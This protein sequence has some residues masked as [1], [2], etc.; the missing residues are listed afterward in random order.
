LIYGSGIDVNKYSSN[1]FER[2]NIRRD[3]GIQEEQ[4]LFICVTRLIW[5]KG[6]KELVDAFTLVHADNK[7]FILYIVGWPDYDNPRHVTDQFINS[8]TKQSGINFL[9]KRTDIPELLA[10]SDLFIFPSYY[11]EGIPRNLLEALAMGLP[12]ITTDMPGCRMAV[13]NGV[14]GLLIQPRSVEEI[15]TAFRKIFGL[16]IL[17]MGKRSRELAIR[18]FKDKIIFQKITDAYKI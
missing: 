3:L 10:A 14:N 9:G 15:L 7:N 1:S 4:R 2:K 18:V 5:E 17:E 6:I 11:R 16:N 8:V 12:I 13:T